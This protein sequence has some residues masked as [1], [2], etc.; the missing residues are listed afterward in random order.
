MTNRGL[1]HRLSVA[2]LVLLSV[3]QVVLPAWLYAL[4]VEGTVVGGG[5]TITQISP[6]TL[7]IQQTAD[8]SIINWRGYSIGVGELVQYIQPSASSI[9]LNRVTGGDPSV[10]LGQ[11]QANGRI[12]L[13]NP[14]GILFGAGSVVDVAGLVASTPRI[15]DSDFLAR[16]FAFQQDPATALATVINRGTMTVSDHGYVLFAAPG[17]ANEGVIVAKVGTV[18]LGS[19]QKFSVDFMGDGL[20]TYALDGPILQQVVNTEG[21]PLSSAVSNSGTIQ[22][23]GGQVILT[24]KSA[25]DIFASVVNNG[26]LIRAQSLVERDGKIVLDGGSS[27][28][29]NVSGTLDASGQGS[30]DTGGTVQ[31]LGEKVGLFAGVKIT[32]SGDA[33]GGT[34][35]IG[36]DFQ[37]KNPEIANAQFSYVDQNATITADAITTGNGGKVIVWADNSTRFYGSI[38][39]RGGSQSGDGGFVEVSGKQNLGFT[40]TVVTSAPE[41]KTGTLLLDPD[42]LYVGVD[43]ANGALP[44]VTD[45]F[46]ATNGANNFYVLAA[47]LSANSN[48]TLQANHDVIFNAD[49]PFGTAAG[50]TVSVTATN[51]I[52]STGFSV[53]TAGGALT[54]TAATLS[55]GAINTNGGL[56]TINNSGTASQS[57]IFAGAGGLTKTGAGT[58]TLSQANTYSGGTTINGGTLSISAD[59]NLGTAPGSA[60]P[61]FLTLNGGTLRTTNDFDLDVN[62]GIALTGTGG[63]F[64]VAT[65]TT[66]VYS[67]IIAGAGA[68]I[69][70]GEGALSLLT[71]TDNTYTG[72][73]TISA[74]DVVLAKD[75]ALGAAPGSATPGHLAFNGGAL[76][77]Q[78]GGFTLA[79]NRGIALTGNGTFNIDSGNTLSYAGI[80][81]GNGALIKGLTGTLMLSGANTYAGLTNVTAGTLRLSGG[82]AIANTGAVQLGSSIIS[83]V[84]RFGTL[85]LASNE[86]IGSLTG[87]AGTNLNLNPNLQ[88][89]TLTVGDASNQVFAGVIS[90]SGGGI[91]KQ[92]TG[93]FTLSGTNSYTGVTT[94]NNGVLSVATIGNGGVAGNLGQATNDAA[95]LVLGGGTLQYT[96]ATASTNRA[97]TL[98]NGT[99]SSID[100]TVEATNLTMSGASAATTGALSKVG[101]GRLTLSGANAYSGKTT[102]TGGNLSISADNNLGVAPGNP[103]ADQLTFNGGALITTAGFTLNANRGITVTGTGLFN[104]SS[105]TLTYGGIITGAGGLTKNSGG[106]LTLTGLNTYTGAT[107][108]NAGVLSVS[109]LVNGG[110]ASGIGASSN[111]AGNLVIDGATLQY[112]GSSVSTD[113][114]VTLASVGRTGTIEVTQA[115]TNLTIS[116]IIADGAVNSGESV[117]KTGAGTLTLSGTNRYT[118][119]TTVSA[120]T[121][122]VTVNNALG[123]DEFDFGSGGVTVANGATLDLQNVAYSTTEAVTLQNGATLATSIGTSSLAGTVTLTTAGMVSVGGAQLTLSG[124]V[125]ESGA[126]ALTKT[127][128][129]TLVLTGANSYTGATTISAGVLNV[130]H[131]TALGTTAGGVTVASGAALELQGGITVGAEALTLNGTGVSNGGAL[132][133]ISGTNRWDG[134]ITLGSATRINGDAGQLTLV[135]GLDNGGFLLTLGGVSATILIQTVGISGAGGLTVDQ[136]FGELALNVASSY[137]GSTT[138][139][140]GAIVRYGVDNALATGTLTVDGGGVGGGLNIGAFSDSVGTVTLLNGGSISGAGGILTSTGTFELQSGSVSAILAGSGIALNKTTSGTVTLSGAN[141]YTGVTTISAGTLSVAT[142]GNGGLAGNLGQAASVAANLVLGGGT[143]RYIGATASTDRAFTLSNGTTSSIDVSTNNLTISGSSAATTGALTKIGAGTLTL[144]GTNSY[145]GTTTVSVGTL[146]VSGGA[147]IANTGAVNLDTAG[148]TFTLA[149]NETIGSLAGVTG[150]FVTLNANTLTTGQNNSTTTYAGIISGGGG[151]TK[152]G[153]G[154]FTLSG[155]NSYD[156]L[157]TISAGAVKVQNNT[158]LGSTA[159]ATIVADGAALQIDGSGLTIAE[160][161]T[162]NGTG[163]SDDGALRNLANNNIWTGAI[164]LGGGARINSDS[165]TLTLATGG[166]TGAGLDLTVGGAGNTTISAVIGTGNGT[167][168]KDGSGMLLLSGHN[169][170][171]GY[172]RLN[173]GLLRAQTDAQALGTGLLRLVSG[174][175][176]LAADVAT[177]FNNNV[178]V[179]GSATIQSNRVTAG[180]GVTHTLGTLSMDTLALGSVTL[181]VEKG[182]SVNSGTAGLTFGATELPNDVTVRADAGTLVT[183]GNVTHT[184]HKLTVDG[185]GNTTLSGGLNTAGNG[186]LTKNGTGTLTLES[187]GNYTGLTT[188]NQGTLAVTANNALGTNEGITT[189]ASGATLNLRSVAYS[190]AEAVTLQDGAIL[191]TSTG[192]SSLAGPV[193]MTTAATVSVGGGAQLT[194]SGVLDEAAPSSALTKSGAGILVLSGNNSYS[195]ST[196][197]SEGTVQA[198]HANALGTAAG[199]TSVSTGANLT[200]NNVTVGEAITLNGTATLRGSGTAGATG[201]VT[202]ADASTATIGTTD[203]GIF[204]LSTGKVTGGAGFT[205]DG[206]GTVVLSSSSNDYQGQTTVSQGTL[207]VTANNALGTTGGI[208]TVA[209]GATLDFRSVTYSTTEAVTLQNGATLAT[210]IGTS[211]LA[212]NVTLT[213]AGTVSVGGTQLTL[214][215]VIDESGTSALTKD[216]SGILVLSG[217]NTYRGLTTVSQGIVQASH[218]NALGTTAGVTSVSTGANLIVNNVTVGEAITLNG[219]ATLRGSG[220]AGVTGNVTLANG[221]TS[222]IGTTDAGTFTLGTGK[223]TGGAGFTKDGVGAVVLSSS[224]NDYTG[225]TTV[226][227]GILTLNGGAAILDTAGVVDVAAG[228]TLNL[229]ADETVSALTSAGLLTGAQTV[230]AATYGFT[231]GTIDA[232]LGTGTLNQSSGSTT[233]NGTAGA[234]TV[235]VTG[236]TLTLGAADRLTNT[237]AVTVSGGTLALG[238]NHSDTVGSLTL[239]T[240]GSLTGTGTSTVRRRPMT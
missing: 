93:T 110:Q 26:G 148:A 157:T 136:S 29:V 229:G 2:L 68:L 132:R 105:G 231:G 226:S 7:Q 120:G 77:V 58:L 104:A 216:G 163:V 171:S 134:A 84:T 232:N 218:A 168:T 159:G 193:T 35:L 189:V 144:S 44:E 73:T 60:T 223:V 20:I 74:G 233:L 8:Q 28:V 123:S 230:T 195:G 190:T 202:L 126:S 41:G 179:W 194:L 135:G 111:G 236:G 81:A 69:K 90:G 107:T 224:T 237:A 75:S 53:T 88:A 165:G 38:S 184:G 176:Q 71:P 46:Q 119:L 11:L 158:A 160:L 206:T 174:T 219:T 37:G 55:L 170:Y 51:N 4:P 214:S 211:S 83:A 196:T 72:A 210:S 129:G 227:Q 131:N 122:A 101:I 1:Y 125:G 220:T 188:V 212:G 133:S 98:T 172:T 12:F 10:I 162:L 173:Q 186:R 34:A 142:I 27:G 140:N 167:L 114:N 215:G 183:V 145:S 197:V 208:T 238:L 89:N 59:S 187:A 31:V 204:T 177:A 209:N 128:T 99:S 66:L 154:T 30:G 108:I 191:V 228:A 14:N 91:T 61:G 240:G 25:G 6:K 52:Q 95:N 63:T 153:T 65:G 24:A 109:T 56:L 3:L 112:T 178:E 152:A 182:A 40:G 86:T 116:G 156:G 150:T 18:F 87:I 130:R 49:L 50:N 115:G 137:T 96:G 239:H 106:T 235:N 32:V 85:Q 203:G 54:L 48:Y 102:I 201:N 138:I 192:T 213:T 57:G 225:S 146:A 13:I 64:D 76:T 19:A 121:L 221:S 139:S 15:S 94:I 222:T 175:V 22:A 151:L 127:G 217:N 36:G 5:S 205:K 9:S 161:L 169:A 70:I 124:V 33:G 45:P 79:A 117:T 207:A 166:V 78:G 67:G 23:D 118:G 200:V 39:A 141:T 17:V 147:A 16:K 113:R 155:A 103:V 92:G 47:S 97:F 185:A 100:V 80:I 180:A 198:G 82:A 181:M 43:P 149:N 199:A 21:V 42:D 143:L 62:R 234:A 164:T